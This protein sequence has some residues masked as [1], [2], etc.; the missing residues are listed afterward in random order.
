MLPRC[1]CCNGTICNATEGLHVCILLKWF[2]YPCHYSDVIKVFGRSAPELS[3]IFNVVIDWLYTNHGHRITQCIHNHGILNLAL[4]DVY[5]N[6][7]QRSRS[8]KLFWVYRWNSVPHLLTYSIMNQRTV[9]NRH[10]RVNAVKFQSVS[11][12][13]GL[14]L[15][16]VGLWVSSTFLFVKYFSFFS[17]SVMFSKLLLLFTFYFFYVEGNMYNTTMLAVSNPYD[18]LENLVFFPTVREMCLYTV[19]HP[20]HS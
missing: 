1:V 14:I 17:F 7:R 13:H 15:V 20:I 3:M 10:K 6:S 16:S 2:A 9:Y 12:P 11:L 4:L 18:N 19:I 8:W 5:I